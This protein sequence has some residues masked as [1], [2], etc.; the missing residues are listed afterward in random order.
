MN[1]SKLEDLLSD[2]DTVASCMFR[3]D[4]YRDVDKLA[5]YLRNILE[6]PEWIP[7]TLRLP[8]GPA[9]ELLVTMTAPPD[10]FQPNAPSRVE[11]TTARWSLGD[12]PGQVWVFTVNGEYPELRGPD[13]FYLLTAW[14]EMPEPFRMEDHEKPEPYR[15][16]W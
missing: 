9:R 2:I 5:T 15:A 10:P 7:V 1:R 3:E 8:E 4:D 13:N 11:V 14:R 6:E 12:N 16:G